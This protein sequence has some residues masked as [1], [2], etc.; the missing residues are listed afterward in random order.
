MH[1]L[2]DWSPLGVHIVTDNAGR[3]ALVDQY[4]ML[5]EGPVSMT[6]RAAVAALSDWLCGYILDS[7]PATETDG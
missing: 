4:R 2:I 1:S 6:D 7:I 3:V 5:L